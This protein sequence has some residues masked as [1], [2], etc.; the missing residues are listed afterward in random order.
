MSKDLFWKEIFF[1]MDLK[2]AADYLEALE[3]NLSTCH[4]ISGLDV[5]FLIGDLNKPSTHK[6]LQLGDQCSK[7]L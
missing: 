7:R 4:S 3:P 2:K 5:L 6:R 1:F